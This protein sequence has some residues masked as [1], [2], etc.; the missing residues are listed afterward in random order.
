LQAPTSIK[1][2]IVFT[3]LIYG[4][5]ISLSKLYTD[6]SST[7]AATRRCVIQLVD[8]KL[9]CLSDDTTDKRARK[10]YLTKEGFDLG[11]KILLPMMCPEWA[12]AGSEDSILS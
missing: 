6:V 8:Q 9:L 7:Q 11:A 3:M 1:V 10:L 5:K 2:Q 4:G 12:A